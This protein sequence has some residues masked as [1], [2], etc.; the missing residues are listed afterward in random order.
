MPVITRSNKTGPTKMTGVKRKLVEI[1]DSDDDITTVCTDSD[2]EF[3]PDS[4]D[5]LEDT[6]DDMKEEIENLRDSE[7]ALIET[8]VREREKN[9]SLQEEL[10]TLKQKH[11]QLVESVKELQKTSWMEVLLFTTVLAAATGSALAAY[12]TCSDDDYVGFQF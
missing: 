4:V 6:L 2:S 7:N 8:I 10:E 3:E 9:R 11:D 12:F 1:L 5:E